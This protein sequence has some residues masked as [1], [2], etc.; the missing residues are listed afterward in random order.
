MVLCAAG[1]HNRL[2]CLM[3]TSI[4]TPCAGCQPAMVPLHMCQASLTVVCKS[5]THKWAQCGICQPVAN[6]CPACPL[7]P[8][9]ATCRPVYVIHRRVFPSS[10]LQGVANVVEA[11]RGGSAT[12]WAVVVS[13]LPRTPAHPLTHPD[14]RHP[15]P[16]CAALRA[17]Q[18]LG[19]QQRHHQP[20]VGARQEGRLR[21]A[22]ERPRRIHLD[23]QRAD[24]IHRSVPPPPPPLPCPTEEAC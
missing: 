19:P 16:R 1:Q 22:P 3:C 15:G 12:H 21:P 17:T 20:R 2:L 13:R 24:N 14:R 8:V 7:V 10:L 9:M 6:R 23:G 11:A 4:A 18:R 5:G